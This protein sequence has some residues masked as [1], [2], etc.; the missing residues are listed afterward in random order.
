MSKDIA[1]LAKTQPAQA[2]LAQLIAAKAVNNV[3]HHFG[4]APGGQKKK[5]A[6]DAAESFLDKLLSDP[7]KL[8]ALYDQFDKHVWDLPPLVDFAA[9][10]LI[11]P[12]LPALI[13]DAVQTYHA[14]GE[15]FGGMS[16]T[17]IQ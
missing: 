3:E 13:D 8:K 4:D 17:L 7:E 10:E 12:H 5:M 15:F 11:I 1:E 14:I 9:K 16:G 2:H 6:L